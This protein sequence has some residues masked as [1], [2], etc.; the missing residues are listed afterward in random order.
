M[1]LPFKAIN[2]RM[3]EIV[4]SNILRQYIEGK[5]STYDDFLL[6]RRT[7]AYQY[8]SISCLQYL[9]SIPLSL[10]NIFINLKNGD[11]SIWNL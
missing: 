3:K 5:S 6:L 1:K 8:G 9:L 7:L 4:P 2:S 10:E 11:I